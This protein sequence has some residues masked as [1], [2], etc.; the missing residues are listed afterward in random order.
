MFYA[1][2]LAFI[3]LQQPLINPCPGCLRGVGQPPDSLIKKEKSFVVRNI[4]VSGNKVSKNFIVTRE[5]TLHPGNRVQGKE[6]PTHLTASKQNLL[7]T[8]L[9]NFV[10]LDTLEL[11]GDSIDVEVKVEERWYTWP[12]PIL[13]FADRNFNIWWETRDPDRLNY[14]FFIFRENFRGRKER[15]TLIFRAGYTRQLG[16][17]Y[18][19]P[20]LDAGQKSG[21]G[22]SVFHS[23]N[24]EVP[25][26]NKNDRLF[27]YNDPVL[28]LKTETGGRFNY[29]YR[30][31]IYSTFQ[32][33]GRYTNI[34]IH[35]TV[36]RIRD[37]FFESGETRLEFFSLGVLYRIDRRDA[38]PYPLEGY[39]TDLEI[40]KSGLGILK[41]EDLELWTA[42]GTFRKFF[43]L[44][45][46]FY[47]AGSLRGKWSYGNFQPW[48]LNRGLGYR[49]YI[50][51]YEY[52]VIDGQKYLLAKTGIKYA[53][54]KPRIK[55]ITFI[56]QPK[57]RKLHYALY[58]ETFFDAGYC[59]DRY[60]Y[61]ANTM[62]NTLQYGYGAGLNFVTYY[63]LVFRLEVSGNRM[64][65]P[66]LFFHFAAPI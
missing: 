4:K 7:N 34:Q 35:D 12:V 62:S 27:F 31:R 11:P 22:F 49:D 45:G 5:I 17:A 56:G 1:G 63:D 50:R 15:L 44:G 23:K 58:V 16:L 38:K 2:F 30:P 36:S 26:E 54:I 6:I 37:D 13:E 32:V 10:N 53:L 9:F 20:F 59:E 46:R 65:L 57:F 41:H 19:I 55:E 3:L 43:K 42:T 60:F 25:I 8:S 29:V 14:G 21:I 51:G 39:Y 28:T 18:Q 48:F 52:Y 24:H 61:K 64:N 47:G 33:E 40:S 66:G